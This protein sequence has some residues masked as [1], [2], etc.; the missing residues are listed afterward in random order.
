MAVI[1]VFVANLFFKL[2]YDGYIV[3]MAYF[4]YLKTDIS[5]PSSERKGAPNKADADSEAFE[6]EE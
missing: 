3:G 1:Y 2:A 6:E 4:E 5:L